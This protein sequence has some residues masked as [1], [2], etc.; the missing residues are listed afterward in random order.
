MTVMLLRSQAI[1]D[2]NRMSCIKWLGFSIL[3]KNKQTTPQ[4]THNMK[5][6]RERAFSYFAVTGYSSQCLVFHISLTDAEQTDP[7]LTIF[8]IQ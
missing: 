5:N 7:E 4:K 3:K 1:L 8:P 6:I 2:S